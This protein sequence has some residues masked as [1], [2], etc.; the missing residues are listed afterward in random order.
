MKVTWTIELP[1]TILILVSAFAEQRTFLVGQDTS[2]PETQFGYDDTRRSPTSLEEKIDRFNNSFPVSNRLSGVLFI[3]HGDSV[4]HHRAYGIARDNQNEPNHVNSQFCIASITKSLTKAIAIQ[5]LME[6]KLRINQPISDWIADFPHGDEI[7]VEHLLRFRAGI[8]HRVTN[9]IDELQSFDLNTMA[10]HT[11]QHVEKHGLVFDPGSKSSY[12]SA[13]YSLLARI[14]EI[15]EQDTFENVLAKRIF[16]PCKMTRTF[17][18]AGESREQIPCQSFVPGVESKV[19]VP[20]FNASFL[21]GAGSVWSNTSDIRR[22]VLG[23]QNP[24]LFHPAIRQSIG[25]EDGLHLTG[26][27]KGFYAFVDEYDE[28]DIRII[29]LGN[30]WNGAASQIRN[31][32]PNMVLGKKWSIPKQPKRGNLELSNRDLEKFEGEYATRPG[33]AINVKAR[34]G[35]LW[36]ADSVVLPIDKHSFFHQVWHEKIRFV[37]R[38]GNG[39]ENNYDL[40]RSADDAP[41]TL[42]RV[43]LTETPQTK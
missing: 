21:A 36:V 37:K 1:L 24:K 28:L 27:T 8:P 39:K 31:Q 16:E 17:D 20:T 30:S 25:S 13:T 26:A 43:I 33:A 29:Y 22:F 18:A 40:I 12:S 11:A 19:P 34:D 4:V 42:H 14:V 2:N 3:E 23:L 6:G 41:S 32:L 5:L 9:S 35:V 7:T 15:V 38:E 10:S